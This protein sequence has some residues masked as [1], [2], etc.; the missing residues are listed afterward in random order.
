MAIEFAFEPPSFAFASGYDRYEGPRICCATVEETKG[1]SFD[2]DVGGWDIP[3]SWGSD[4]EIIGGDGPDWED[5]EAKAL[6]EEEDDEA[7]F[8]SRA[9]LFEGGRARRLPLPKRVKPMHG[10]HKEQRRGRTWS[11]P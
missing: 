9:G 2:N 1:F 3:G 8:V 4:G 7:E 6:P 5:E 11:R 10:F